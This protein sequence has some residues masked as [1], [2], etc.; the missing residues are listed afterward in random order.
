MITIRSGDREI[1]IQGVKDEEISISMMTWENLET[2][3]RKDKV[4]YGCFLMMGNGED[5]LKAKV[6]ENGPLKQLLE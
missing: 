3:L 2:M 1:N 6:L 4:T 5:E